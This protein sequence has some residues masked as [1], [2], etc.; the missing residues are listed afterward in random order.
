MKTQAKYFE[1]CPA[2]I[3]FIL[4]LI[5]SIGVGFA[6]PPQ[7]G[8]IPTYKVTIEDSVNFNEF[9]EKYEIIEQDGKYGLLSTG[10]FDS[11]IVYPIICDSI[12]ASY[13]DLLIIEVNGKLGLLK[14]EGQSV[15]IIL[16]PIHYL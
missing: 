2:I 4:S 6:T 7:V 16:K 8:S 15:R 10:Y 14:M 12:I 11:E 3:M 5:F 9:N 13:I 1:F